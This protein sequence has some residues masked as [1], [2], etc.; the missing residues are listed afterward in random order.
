MD[1]AFRSLHDT[2][3]ELVNQPPIV[4]D[5]PFAQRMSMTAI[6]IEMP[7]ELDLSRSGEDGELVIGTTPPLYLLKSSVLPSFH[8]MRLRASLRPEHGPEHGNE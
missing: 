2:I 3:V 4:G 6:E 1:E 8:H 7:V 5:G